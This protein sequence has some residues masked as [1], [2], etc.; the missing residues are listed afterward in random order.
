MLSPKVP[1]FTIDFGEPNKIP[2]H[3]H[4][5]VGEHLLG[6]HYHRIKNFPKFNPK[7]KVK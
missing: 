7:Y 6:K 1:N 5:L 2:C 3:C 4:D